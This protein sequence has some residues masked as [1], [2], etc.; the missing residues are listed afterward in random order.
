V[1]LQKWYGYYLTVIFG[2]TNRQS[3][4]ACVSV[5]RPTGRDG[6]DKILAPMLISIPKRVLSP[7]YLSHPFTSVS[8]LIVIVERQQD[9][10]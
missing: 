2:N 9:L 10:D 4:E 7:F 6:T 8:I 1:S 5:M 3:N